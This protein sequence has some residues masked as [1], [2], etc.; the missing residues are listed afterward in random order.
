MANISMLVMKKRLGQE[1]VSKWNSLGV[2]VELPDQET[3][4]N[5]NETVSLGF[6]SYNNLGAMMSD[7]STGGNVRSGK[8][9]NMRIATAIPTVLQSVS[10][11]VSKRL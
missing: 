9:M 5:N 4:S 1:A 10:Q 7:S 2:K 3:I 8:I 11:S 6:T